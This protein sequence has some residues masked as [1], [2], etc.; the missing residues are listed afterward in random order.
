[1]ATD[2]WRIQPLKAEYARRIGRC[3][4]QYCNLLLNTVNEV[5]CFLRAF[6]SIADRLNIRPDVFQIMRSQCQNLRWTDEAREHRS[7][8]IRLGGANVAQVLR[9]NEVGLD[10]P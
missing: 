6:T 5:L 2:K 3:W 4:R 7:Q 10:L 8:A 1:M 9:N